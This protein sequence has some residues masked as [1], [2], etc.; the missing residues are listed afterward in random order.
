MMIELFPAT[1]LEIGKI[2]A[3]QI[4]SVSPISTKQPLGPHSL[5]PSLLPR[6]LGCRPEGSAWARY[7]KV[8]KDFAYKKMQ[9]TKSKMKNH[10]SV[11]TE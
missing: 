6:V 10:L 9:G 8:M 7:K 1:L 5:W 2:E 3:V 11:S 4:P